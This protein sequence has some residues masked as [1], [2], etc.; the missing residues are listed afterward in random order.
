MGAQ[1]ETAQNDRQ[2]MSEIEERMAHLERA[3]DDMSDVM[4]RQANEIALL[5]RRVQVLLEREKDRDQSAEGGV[6]FGDERPP[7][8]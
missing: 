5:T 8:Y 4:A 2:S 3:I 1:R 6:V 7:H